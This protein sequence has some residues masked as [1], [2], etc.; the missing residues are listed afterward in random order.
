MNSKPEIRIAGISDAAEVSCLL[1]GAMLT[2]CADS[3]ISSSMLEAMT[4]SIESVADRILKQ[5]CLVAESDGK[6]VGTIC[7]K[8]VSNPFALFAIW[9]LSALPPWTLARCREHVRSN[10]KAHSQGP[11]RSSQG[12]PS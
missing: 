12:V 10:P 7:I 5:T 4:E 1:K 6:I 8:P 2:Y 3:G 11:R 9:L